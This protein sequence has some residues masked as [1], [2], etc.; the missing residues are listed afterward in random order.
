MRVAHH[1]GAQEDVRNVLFFD[2]ELDEF[3]GAGH[4]DQPVAV[5]I[6]ALDTEKNIAFTALGDG[7]HHRRSLSGAHGVFINDDLDAAVAIAQIGRSVTGHE[8]MRSQP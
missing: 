3:G 4:A 2:G 7:Q 1:R 8:D 5:K 6:F